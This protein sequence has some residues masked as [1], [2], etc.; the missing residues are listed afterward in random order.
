L[1]EGFISDGVHLN[2]TSATRVADKEDIIIRWREW[3]KGAFRVV[4]V[5]DELKE[6][7]DKF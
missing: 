1:Q 2:C 5:E 3:D 6:S 7:L 4:H